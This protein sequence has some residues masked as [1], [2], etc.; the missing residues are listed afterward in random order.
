VLKTPGVAGG[1]T[2]SWSA[3]DTYTGQQNLYVNDSTTGA[4]WRQETADAGFGRIE[5]TNAVV[6]TVNGVSKIFVVDG[7]GYPGSP[8]TVG[9]SGGPS[10]LVRASADGGAT[11][12]SWAPQGANGGPAPAAREEQ[13]V[14]SFRGKLW[15]IGG[16]VA[17]RGYVKEVWS[18]PDGVAWT[19]EPDMPAGFEGRGQMGS[20]V[21]TDGSTLY[22]V[23]GFGTTTAAGEVWATTDGAN[24]ELKTGAAPF[25]QRWGMGVVYFNNRL[26]LMGGLDGQDY[27]EK[28]DVWSSPDGATWTLV[29][30]AP[31]FGVRY[32]SAAVVHDNRMWLIGGHREYGGETAYPS[33][34]WYSFDGVNW[35]QAAQGSQFTRGGGM[36]VSFGGR[37]VYM[38]GDDPNVDKNDVW[39]AA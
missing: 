22:L 34:A 17:N 4:V 5:Q 29:T 8:G 27:L 19:R 11:W 32:E 9:T 6:H 2:Y 28:G 25:H 35:T 26:W 38:F 16:L 39:S 7:D 12:S 36:A 13:T 1:V 24:W 10:S 30:A 14:V 31:A 15:M 3:T 21:S 37:I 20:A 23:G 33:D 18:S